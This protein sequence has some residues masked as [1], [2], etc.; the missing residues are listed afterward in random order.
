MRKPDKPILF[1]TPMVRA[2]LA[3]RKTVTRRLIKVAPSS[4][5]GRWYCDRV[6]PTGFQWTGSFGSPRIPYEPRF[7]RGMMLWVKES[8]ELAGSEIRYAATDQ[9]IGPMKPSI[10][11]PRA[12]SRITLRVREVDVARLHDITEDQARTEGVETFEGTFRGGF[13]TIWDEINGANGPGSWSANPWVEAV[14]F[15]VELRNIDAKEAA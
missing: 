1:S 11:M 9:I 3:G 12:L 6:G 15:S 10:F 2:L 14:S 13:A 4:T 8:Y 5:D 7:S